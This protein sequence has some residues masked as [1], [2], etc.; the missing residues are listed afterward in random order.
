MKPI[1][2]TF[3]V[4]E[5][6][7]GVPGVFI[8][9]VYVYFKTISTTDAIELQ[10]RTTLNGVPTK[11]TLP[12]A[13]KII[14]PDE[15][16]D[17]G[18]FYLNAS[19]D[20][21]VPSRFIF[22]T[23]VFVESNKSYAL[24]VFPPGGN[25][26]GGSYQIWTSEIGLNDVKSGEAV[27]DNNDT[28]DLFL[29]SNDIS[30]TPIITED[31]KFS[32]FI[33]EFTSTSGSAIF[34]SPN[35]EYLELEETVGTFAEKE[36]LFIAN[37][38]ISVA[39]LTVPSISGGAFS[40]ND[41]V[42]QTDDD[43]ALGTNTATGKVYYSSGSII[44]VSNTSG[45]FS[46]STF[47]K[48]FKAGAEVSG[49]VTAVSQNASVTSTANTFTLPDPSLFSEGDYIYIATSNMSNTNIF[50]V[51]SVGSTTLNFAN[52]Y[53]ASLANSNFT[54]QN[55]IYGHIYG[56]TEGKL[57]GGMGAIQTYP[58]FTRAIIDNVH[59][60]TGNGYFS[61]ANGLK[62]V[63]M[64]SS[65][66]SKINKTVSFVYNQLSPQ[67]THVVPPKTEISWSFKGVKNDGFYT[68]DADYIDIN[69]GT[70]NELTDSERILMSRSAELQNRPGGTQSLFI[71]ADMI[72]SNTKISPSVDVLT[73]LTHFTRNNSF[74][75]YEYSGYY[76]NVT[77]LKG[78]FNEGDIIH[79][80]NAVAGI[81]RFANSSFIRVTNVP[82]GTYFQAQ[83]RTINSVAAVT[84]TTGKF[85]CSVA[86]LAYGDRI[87]ITGT[88]TG[89]GS[90]TDYVSGTVYKVSAVTGTSP[91]VTGFTLVT[92]AG[93]AIE[94][95]VGSLTGL[96]FSAD[97]ALLENRTG[98]NKDPVQLANA[99]ITTAEYYSESYDNGYFAAPRYISKSVGLAEPA[100]D[101]LVYLAA[102]RPASASI[103]VYAKISNEGD[104]NQYSSKDWTLLYERSSPSLVSSSVNI[105][106]QVELSYSFPQS[107]NLFPNSVSFLGTTVTTKT[108]SSGGAS[109]AFTFI[110]ASNVTN[111]E[112]GQI[113]VGT[114]VPDNTVVTA[115][116]SVTRT[117]TLS[118][119]FTGQASGSY[120]FR[121]P[122]TTVTLYSTDNLYVGSYIYLYDPDLSK[123]NVRQVTGVLDNNTIYIDSPPS[124]SSSDASIGT[125]PIKS[126][127]SAF[128]NDQNF[129]IVRYVT[130]DDLVFDSY[131]TFSIK[132]V[133]GSTSTTIV[134]RVADMR[135]LAIQA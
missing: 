4:N 89:S 86:T 46:S 12:F 40:V 49:D 64:Y 23:P 121:I 128:L 95:S 28:G 69:E 83:V 70:S 76:L 73:K 109:G 102:Y 131:S 58:D 111:I 10:I 61:D 57:N 114:Y 122:N 129:N 103:F 84:D 66:T 125:I 134:P 44:K 5:P 38:P 47:P 87:T 74:P 24:V 54:D 2:Q 7:T 101:I 85:S 132:I 88:L 33:A 113:V 9:E 106:D 55:C 30:W 59:P 45:A 127:H 53:P 25:Q 72:S 71:K 108:Y 93:Q 11:E 67:I 60:G 32:I 6:A 14:Y 68:D 77:N 99:I 26:S 94:T 116:D 39:K 124:F 18:D 120:T 34:S 119:A 50:K 13:S 92:E 130:S 91:R 17:N 56:G 90:I 75:Q 41:E 27:T 97:C 96:T 112:L 3:Y 62:L 29:S 117:I 135:V 37:T 82:T 8:K 43:T 48:L 133:L 36:P 115:I 107:V 118:K 110:V 81:V 15:V 19:S 20:A 31:M 98:A 126:R 51:T 16:D 35:E 100:E 79:Q 80:N 105:D 21:S 78:N 42:Y 123:Y 104:P 63:G 52:V 1:G 65:A 22:E